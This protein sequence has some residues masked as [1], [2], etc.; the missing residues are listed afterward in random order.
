[1]PPVKELPVRGSQ[2]LSRGPAA[3]NRRQALSLLASGIA[4]GLAACSKPTEEIIPYVK[5]PERIVPGEALKFA[6]TLSLSGFGRGVIVTSIDGRPIKVD[7]NPR[8]PASLGATD[9]F[10]EATVLSLY[11]PDRSRAILKKDE[12]ASPEAFRQALQAQL[13]QM[14]QRN[15][16]GFRLLTGRVTS[17]TLLRQIDDLLQKFPK[18]A[19]HAY[20]P[21]DEDNAEAGAALA[22]GRPLRSLPQLDKARVLV[23][24]DADPLGQGPS[25]LSNARGFA[26][27]RHPR[28]G[29]FS[30]IYSIEAAPTLTG[31]KADHRMA[32]QPQLIR[33]MAIAIAHA[34]GAP[35]RDASLPD[36]AMR[37]AKQAAADLS[38]NHGAAVV[39]AGRALSPETH[40]LVHWINAQLQA[41]IDQIEIEKT[42][43]ARSAGT[44][45][46]LVLDLDA[47]A[48][49]QLV[50][51]GVNPG[52][53]AAADLEFA[54][55]SAKAAF[56]LHLGRYADETADLATWHMP[57][58]HE[59]E[60]WSD[61]RSS[62]GTASLVQPLI[63]P[64]FRSWTDHELLALLTGR[65]DASPY[66]LVRETWQ[67]QGG[68]DFDGWWTR[69]LHDGVIIGSVPAS[70]AVGQPRLPGYRRGSFA[71]HGYDPRA[72]A[73]PMPVGRLL[74]Q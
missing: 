50:M 38:A 63:R 24:L 40:A 15:G 65:D 69:A 36:Q 30:R 46:D 9:V 55:R 7:G 44:L 37:L 42:P 12:I 33:E 49:D 25:Q 35:V 17:P 14:Q 31:A 47:G 21:I 29:E 5:E 22:F 52:Y 60:A 71:R 41:P 27:R 64:L 28:E 39:L 26:A 19:W 48:V 6:T 1:M 59:L 11:D 73:R 70:T 2:F 61:L 74:C 20:E 18:A 8:H 13:Q 62:D 45:A 3:L 53:D 66:D 58:T 67:P 10:A 57:Q 68:S 56:R 16:E 54:K 43:G 23:A 34:M 32:L 51:I 72:A 4:S